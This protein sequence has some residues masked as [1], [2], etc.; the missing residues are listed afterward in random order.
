M[1]HTHSPFRCSRSNFESHSTAFSAVAGRMSSHTRQRF[2]LFN[3]GCRVTRKRFRP[4][5][6][7]CRFTLDSVFR[8]SI[9]NIESYSTALCALPVR[10]SSHSAFC[11]PMSNVESH[12]RAHSAV[13]GRMSSHARQRFL[14][15]QVECR[16]TRRRLPPFE[17][18]CRAT[19][20]RAFQP[21]DLPSMTRPSNWNSGKLCRV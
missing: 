7:E 6:V 1:S 2:L 14:L 15:F 5:Q 13:P 3:V 12:S 19:F 20:D 18:E 17:V 9:S 8:L 16:V 4:F 10:M 21:S 11:C